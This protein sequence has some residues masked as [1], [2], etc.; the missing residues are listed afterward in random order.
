MFLICPMPTQHKICR[1]PVPCIGRV[2]CKRPRIRNGFNTTRSRSSV[3]FPKRIYSFTKTLKIYIYLLSTNHSFS[4][5]LFE[6]QNGQLS[7]LFWNMCSNIHM[8]E[9]CCLPRA[10]P[11]F[12][13]TTLPKESFFLNPPT[14]QVCAR[15]RDRLWDQ[16]QLRPHAWWFSRFVLHTEHKHHRP[17]IPIFLAFIITM[18]S[19]NG[20]CCL[21]HNLKYNNYYVLILTNHCELLHYTSFEHLFVPRESDPNWN[22]NAERN[23]T[24]RLRPMHNFVR[25]VTSWRSA[26]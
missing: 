3:L 15:F 8:R 14:S 20:M 11:F 23:I 16:Q 6:F 2:S 4:R 17:T 7:I 9:I 22:E 1:I 18:S 10:C 25:I 13:T 24:L 21:A 5:R 26:C 12:A 19:K